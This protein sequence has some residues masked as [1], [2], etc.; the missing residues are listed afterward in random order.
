M[1]LQREKTNTSTT[2]SCVAAAFATLSHPCKLNWFAR[3]DS[4]G[5]VI[6]SA[7][8]NGETNYIRYR[9]C[10]GPGASSARVEAVGT[11]LLSRPADML[12][13]RMAHASLISE[14]LHVTHNPQAGTAVKHVNV[15]WSLVLLDRYKHDERL[16]LMLLPGRLQSVHHQPG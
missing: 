5:I 14:A 7:L 1:L 11:V 12:I 2:R 8:Q 15:V 13:I 9:T 6:G 3:S 10:L 4:A 16:P